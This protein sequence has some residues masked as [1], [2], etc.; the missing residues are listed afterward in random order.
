[1]QLLL[2]DAESDFQIQ[3][4]LAKADYGMANAG[5]CLYIGTQLVADARPDAWE[6]A[7]SK[8]ARKLRGRADAALKGGHHESARGMYLRACEYFRNG[9]FYLRG[10][11]ED[12]RLVFA[13]RASRDCFEAAAALHPY[14]IEP[15]ELPGAGSDSYTGY[16]GRPGGEG[17]FPLVVAPGG[18]DSTA[19]EL[20][21]T[22]A[23]GVSRG[24][25]V[26]AF[27]GPGQ[28]GTLFDR[29]IPMRPDWESVIPPVLDA[30]LE[31]PELDPSRVALLGRSFGGYLCPRAASGEDRLAALILDP[32]QYDLGAS[33]EKRLPAAL[34]QRLDEDS[35]AARASFDALLDDEHS[36]RL[37]E[38]RMATHGAEGVQEYCRMMLDYTNEGRAELIRCPT[39]VCDN[40]T[41][42]VSTGQGRQLYD[43][44][45][46]PKDFVRF[47][48][49]EGAEGHIEG[50]A[51]VVFYE[52]AF[53]WLDSTFGRAA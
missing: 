13:Y 29:R 24:Y 5:E 3:R 4:S 35:D 18:Y 12:E 21:P 43:A 2:D 50:M 38:P 32:G 31:R 42:I 30:I 36:R 6:Q 40:E 11:L 10:N 17:P 48:A 41:D 34:L 52:R 26:L 20:Y 46:C 14:P 9:F 37:F 7:F 23:A 53:D 19:E 8:F 45:S 22:L 39:L 33:L 16:L 27:D 44:L 15:C 1:M 51:A 49:A 28:G 47:T 25:A